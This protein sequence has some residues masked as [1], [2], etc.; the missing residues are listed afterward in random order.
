MGLKEFFKS[1]RKNYFINAKFQLKYSLL[2]A[3][4][5]IL[6]SIIIGVAI[7]YLIND[8][9]RLFSIAGLNTLP[10][11]EIIL[12]DHMHDL[13]IKIT[14]LLKTLPIISGRIIP[15]RGPRRQSRGILQQS[16]TTEQSKRP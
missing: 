2:L 9:F 11:L 13:V 4:L 14:F 1:Q 5:G 15:T 6:T 16:K 12:S 3:F 10:N 7:I 8:A